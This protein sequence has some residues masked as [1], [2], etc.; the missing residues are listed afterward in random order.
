[1]Y[2]FILGLLLIAQ[3][4]PVMS[5]AQIPIFNSKVYCDRLVDLIK[6][7][8]LARKLCVDA[9]DAVRQDVERVWP[10]VPASV[11]KICMDLT[12][13]EK[14]ANY[15]TFASCLASSVGGMWL[16]GGLKLDPN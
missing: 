6:G 3:V 16:K 10:Q 8:I 15:Q 7:D 11:K 1:M 4:E 2:R 12:G 9:E 5:Q 13:T 14:A